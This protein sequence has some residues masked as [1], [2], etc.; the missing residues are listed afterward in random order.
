MA[1][2]PNR[3]QRKHCDDYCRF[4]PLHPG[5]ETGQCKSLRLTVEDLDSIATPK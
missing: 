3:R 5:Y 1:I 2:T 4:F